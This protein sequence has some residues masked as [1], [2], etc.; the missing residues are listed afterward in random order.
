VGGQNTYEGRAVTTPSGGLL[1]RGHPLGATGLAR[2]TELVWQLRGSAGKR[3]GQGAK[4][5][6]QHDLSLGGARVVTTYR[7]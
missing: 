1:S 3:R 6:L 2:C 7:A 5:A 4:V